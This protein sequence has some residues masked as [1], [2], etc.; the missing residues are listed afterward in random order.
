MIEQKKLN[1]AIRRI[2]QMTNTKKTE[3]MRDMTCQRHDTC[4]PERI[5]GG[6]MV[7]NRTYM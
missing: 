6:T 2:R 1:E 5:K 4:S 7:T 3:I